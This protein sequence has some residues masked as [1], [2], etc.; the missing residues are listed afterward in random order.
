MVTY[1]LKVVEIRK[2]TVEAVTV[3]FKQPG[4]KKTKYLAGQY[5]TLIFR[6]NGGR[7]IRP[8]SFASAPPV[9]PLLEIS[10]KRVPAY[11]HIQHRVVG[12]LT[13]S[14]IIM[15]QSFWLSVWSILNKTHFDYIEDVVKNYIAGA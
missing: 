13:N 5:L 11:T 7:Y 10:V 6:I 14:D 15:N 8:Y 9:D 12:D 4:I 3:C 2:E 1:T